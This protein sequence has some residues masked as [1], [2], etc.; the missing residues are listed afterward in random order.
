[1]SDVIQTYEVTA[2]RL[3]SGYL[4]IRGDGPCNWAQVPPNWTGDLAAF[5]EHAFLEASEEF[6]RAAYSYASR[7]V[8]TLECPVCR[9]CHDLPLCPERK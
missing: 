4:H 7:R 8:Q 5:R 3:E 6:V 1:M 2:R 9:T